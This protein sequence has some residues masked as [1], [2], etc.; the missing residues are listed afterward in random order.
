MCENEHN[1]TAW[2]LTPDNWVHNRM[3][4]MLHG[5][6]GRG[7][8][9]RISP[10]NEKKFWS[11]VLKLKYSSG[12]LHIPDAINDS[13]QI[14]EKA[15]ANMEKYFVLWGD[16]FELKNFFCILRY[17]GRNKSRKLNPDRI[18]K[19]RKSRSRTESPEERW[20][21]N[22]IILKRN[23]L[24]EKLYNWAMVPWQNIKVEHAKLCSP[25]PNT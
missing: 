25:E 7:N 9:C 13:E 15:K 14:L 19:P 12:M 24:D 2:L 20:V 5:R 18:T 6:K 10:R 11:S 21:N 22:R 3:T 8:L 4:R 17:L 23:S 16:A 1:F